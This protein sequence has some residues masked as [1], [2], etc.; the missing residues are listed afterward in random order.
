MSIQGGL[1]GALMIFARAAWYPSYAGTVQQ[2]GLT[3][4]EDQQLAGI[5]MWLPSGI[6]Y[7]LLALFFLANWLNALEPQAQNYRPVDRLKDRELI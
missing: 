7:L 6:L 5:I 2:W 1:L 3:L 4:L